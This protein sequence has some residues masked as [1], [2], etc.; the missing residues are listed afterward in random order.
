M[1]KNKLK[2]I[3]RIACGEYMAEIIRT[4]D[5]RYEANIYQLVSGVH[6]FIETLQTIDPNNLPE[7]VFE[8]LM[9]SS[10]EKDIK[11]WTIF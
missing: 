10:G 6:S 7:I 1:V 9:S 2:S 5:N 3:V 8:Y 4:V 11:I